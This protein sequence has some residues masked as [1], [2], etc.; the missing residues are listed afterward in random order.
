M[1]RLAITLAMLVLIATACIAVAP[2]QPV[3]VKGTAMLPA[4]KEGD[5]III[6]RNPLEAVTLNVTPISLA[7]L[8][9]ALSNC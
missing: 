8:R 2:I 6:E 9:S 4:L 3:A 7:R 5:R 1:K